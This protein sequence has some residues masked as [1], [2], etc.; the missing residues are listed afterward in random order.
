MQ[1]FLFVVTTCSVL[2]LSA[3]GGSS[4]NPSPQP[5][6]DGGGGNGN[7]NGNGGGTGDGDSGS[8]PASQELLVSRRGGHYWHDYCE[9]KPDSTA[10]PA[11]PREMIVPGVNENKAVLMN[12][13]WQ[14]CQDDN[15]PANCGELRQR[16]E[17]G[18]ALVAAEGRPGAASFFAGDASESSYSF[19]ADAYAEMWKSVWGL[20]ER[21]A[22]YDELVAQRWGMPL[23]VVRNPYPLPGEDPN[24][25]ANGGGSGQLPM[26]ITQLRE[27]D[28]TLDRS[29]QCDLQYLSWW[30][31]RSG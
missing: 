9:G 23:S 10:V 14:T 8:N 17:H 13:W 6:T 1:K 25:N 21:P 4:S 16:R 11:D 20:S 24:A 27:A 3:C 15:Q 30:R 29:A 12:A 7:G 26:G 19:P 18:L 2:L 28:G 22:Q 31:G 5:V